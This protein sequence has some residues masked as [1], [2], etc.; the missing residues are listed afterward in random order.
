METYEALAATPEGARPHKPYPARLHCLLA[1]DTDDALVVRRG[2]SKQTAVYHWDRATDTFTLGQWLNGKIYERR[3]DISRDGRHWIYFAMNGR[4]FTESKGSWTAVA[5]TGWLKA[6]AF[7]PKGDCWEGG[8]LFLEHG[9]YWLNDRWFDP[10]TARQDPQFREGGPG[11]PHRDPKASPG[12]YYNAECLTPYYNR[13]QRDG[14]AMAESRSVLRRALARF[15]GRGLSLAETAGEDALTGNGP[16][17]VGQVFTKELPDG[18]GVLVKRAHVGCNPPPG[19]GCYWDDHRLLLEDGTVDEQP[20]W[21]WADVDTARGRL[22]WAEKGRLWASGRP[23][24]VGRKRPG[25]AVLLRD[26]N[27]DRFEAREA[28]Y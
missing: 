28:P 15:L 22:V 1:R 7:Y 18:A 23:W 14:W 19:R 17:G 27:G 9:G 3:C 10:K 8:G 25:N 13:L 16:W 24:R 6:L 26:F 12:T 2:P 4:W 11:I 20:D 5:Q 21:E